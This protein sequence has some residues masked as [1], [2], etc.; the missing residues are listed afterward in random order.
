MAQ[1]TAL[2][3][4]A[5]R[6]GGTSTSLELALDQYQA[7]YNAN[8]ALAQNKEYEISN[9]QNSKR[10]LTRA[11]A[12]EVKEML[13]YWENEVARLQGE[14]INAPKINTIYTVGY[15]Q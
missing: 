1:K 13:N 15:P 2:E 11:D 10:K 12:D 9:G 3:L 7:W 14:S 4:L 6:I 8:L 5:E